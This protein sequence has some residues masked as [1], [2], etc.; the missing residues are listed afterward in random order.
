MGYR[1]STGVPSSGTR[2]RGP[3]ARAPVR[4]C[5]PRAGGVA[6]LARARRGDGLKRYPPL[7]GLVSCVSDAR[8]RR[9]RA[10]PRRN[11]GVSDARRGANARERDGSR[12]CGSP[13]ERVWRHP[14]GGPCPKEQARKKGGL[15]CALGLGKTVILSPRL[16]VCSYECDSSGRKRESAT[17]SRGT[18]RFPNAQL[19]REKPKE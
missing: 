7:P 1:G 3:R 10:C 5:A 14:E 18:D 17:S 9:E 2:G 15:H 6:R 11:P 12:A 13:R 4:S 19:S 8:G 16:T